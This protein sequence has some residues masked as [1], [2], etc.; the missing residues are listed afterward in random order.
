MVPQ[1]NARAP[2]P[3]ACIDLSKLLRCLCL[4]APEGA[5]NQALRPRSCAIQDS[6][7]PESRPL[8]QPLL[9]GGLGFQAMKSKVAIATSQAQQRL[10]V[11]VRPRHKR[12]RMTLV[13]HR[14]TRHPCSAAG[15]WISDQRACCKL[16][17]KKPAGC[18]ILL[19]AK[20]ARLSDTSSVP[21][22][23]RR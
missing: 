1:R 7:R 3:Q 20:P 6:F 21:G 23:L 12:S 17:G 19:H 13:R 9:L 14:L 5:T 18:G 10:G 2:A 16:G 15:R 8:R 4:S 22:L 11:N